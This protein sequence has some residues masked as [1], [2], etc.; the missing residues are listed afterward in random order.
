VRA[1]HERFLDLHAGPVSD[2]N[3]SFRVGSNQAD[4]LLT[5]HVLARFGRSR[6]PLDV[7]VVRQWI[8]DGVDIRVGDERVV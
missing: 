5:E 6:C 4:R 1:D 7:Q 3:Q 2:R 8:V